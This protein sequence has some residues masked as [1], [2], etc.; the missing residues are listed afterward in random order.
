MRPFRGKRTFD[1]LFTALATVA[2]VH[3]KWVAILK[4]EGLAHLLA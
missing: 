1:R 4:A 2:P 3:R